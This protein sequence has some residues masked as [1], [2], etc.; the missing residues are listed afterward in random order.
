MQGFERIQQGR[1][2]SRV[3]HNQPLSERFAR[4]VLLCRKARSPSI[5]CD[6]HS[7]STKGVRCTR[8]RKGEVEP[9]CGIIKPILGFRQFFLRGFDAVAGERPLFNVGRFLYR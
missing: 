3:L 6:I 2:A 1:L 8:K 9:V 5:R 4:A 7:K